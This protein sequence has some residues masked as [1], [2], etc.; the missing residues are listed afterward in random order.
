M[1]ELEVTGKRRSL[2]GLRLEGTEISTLGISKEEGKE[3]MLFQTVITK[4]LGKLQIMDQES[5]KWQ[6]IIINLLTI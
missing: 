1:K 4:V 2:R 5:I 3:S 6:V